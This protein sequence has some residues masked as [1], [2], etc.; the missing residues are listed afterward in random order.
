MKRWPDITGGLRIT[1]ASTSAVG[2]LIGHSDGDEDVTNLLIQ[3][4]VISDIDADTSPWLTTTKG[5]GAYGI[6]LSHGG[7]DTGKTIDAQVLDNTITDLEGLWAHGIGLEGNTPGAVISG[8][9][10][11]NLTDHKGSTDAV[12]IQV[13]SNL[14]AGT[15]A[16]GFNNF[17]GVAICIQN[18]TG[19][20]VTAEANWWGDKRG[21]S[22]A[23]GK[24]K[25]HD[26]VKG[27]KVSPNVRFAP[28]L[29][30]PVD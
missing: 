19:I 7:G 22:R 20:L 14:G 23:M 18:T 16:I 15:V 11:S 12:A 5:Q 10:I 26:E 27:A 29:Q 3:D 28:W 30:A 13:E 25:G 4:N 21:P 9:I 1:R 6:L 2:I 24:A 8:N 17:S